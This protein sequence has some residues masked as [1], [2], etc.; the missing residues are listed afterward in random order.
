[1]HDVVVIGGGPVGSRAAR[2]LAEYGCDVLVLEK[3]KRFGGKVCCAGIIGIECIN[4]FGIDNS[5]IFRRVNSARV[6]SPSNKLIHL[7]RQQEQA[8]IIDRAQLDY[9]MAEKAKAAGAEYLLDVNARNIEIRDDGV[10]VE[11]ESNGSRVEYKARAVIIAA[12][13]NSKLVE[14]AG[15]GKPGDYV[16]GAQVEVTAPGIDEI[17][18]YTGGKVTPGFF[19]WLVPASSQKALVGLMARKAPKQYLEKLVQKLKLEGKITGDTGEICCRGIT[20]KPIARTYG[21][22]LIVVGDAA[23]Q[24]KPITGGGIYFGLLS[25]DIAA[26][27]LKNALEENNLSAKNL[28]VYQRLWR[29]KLG[30]DINTGCRARRIYEKLGDR[31]IDKIIDI[32]KDGGII[33]ALLKD[34][35]L[36]FDWHGKAISRVLRRKALAGALGLIKSPFVSTQD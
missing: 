26:E 21:R 16:F 24:V 2:K 7:R 6:F 8:A 22:R 36:S 3:R 31:Q 10:T 17:E 34:E 32:T 27:S 28:A 5:L 25:A 18:V 23:G 19:G 13:F 4:L 9:Y 35:S 1:M 14:K 20:I 15:L 30:K 12:G 11:A 33:D 29:Q